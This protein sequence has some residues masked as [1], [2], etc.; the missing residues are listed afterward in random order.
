MDIEEHL[1]E[2]KDSIRKIA[3]LHAENT[4]DAEDIQQA[5]VHE[6]IKRHE[7]GAY[8]HENEWGASL[9][10]YI[11]VALKPVVMETLNQSQHFDDGKDFAGNP[12]KVTV[13]P[14]VEDPDESG[15]SIEEYEEQDGN[16]DRPGGKGAP[17]VQPISWHWAGYG[18][19][20]STL[21]AAELDQ[22]QKVMANLTDE[23]LAIL[24]ASYG[25]SERQAAEFLAMPKTTYRYK[26]QAAQAKAR[27][28]LAS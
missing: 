27:D 9:L 16:P 28:L 8:D 23:E 25:R 12:V 7:S 6:L 2:H 14:A 4:D 18:E 10:T 17:R 5:I 19:Q 11:R 26:L 3:W 13:I 20:P 21:T 1:E 24:D 22:A 15:Y